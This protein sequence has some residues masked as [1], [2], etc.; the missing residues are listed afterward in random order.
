[1]R[2]L[3]SLTRSTVSRTL[4]VAAIA[5]LPFGAVAQEL[6]TGVDGTFAP[7][8]MPNL[9]GGVQGFNIDLANELAKRL[10]SKITIDATQFSGLVPGMQAGTYD[11][12]A[13]PVTANK[14]RAEQ[15]LFTEGYLNTD[16]QFVV[17]KDTADITDLA[18]LKGKVIAVNKGS[19]Y[20][21]WARELADKMGWTVESYGTNSDAIQ[22]VVTGRAYAN[23]AGNTVSAWAVKNNPAIKLSYL[24]STGLVWAIPV[25]K[26]NAALRNKL[27]AA[28]ECMK[29]DGTMAAL[30]EKWFG[31]KPAAGAAAV[32]IFPGYG[33]PE[34]PGYDKTEHPLSCS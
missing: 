25:R 31:T 32:T 33:V 28:I 10:G 11:F 5:A 30:H 3:F 19:A 2:H 29:K 20:D 9:S 12:I 7:H 23:V 17:K 15:M 16:F 1:M 14:D 27:D 8:A 24:H 22:A 6:K 21:S 18:Q 26:D 13:A 34:L 4:A